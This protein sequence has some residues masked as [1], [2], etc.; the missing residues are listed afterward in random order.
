MVK[1]SLSRPSLGDARRR[2]AA[3]EVS[4][5][6]QRRIGAGLAWTMRVWCGV[7]CASL[8]AVWF[9]IMLVRREFPRA[10]TAEGAGP[11]IAVV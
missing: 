6:F 7:V 2:G 9:R 5:R 11:L 1:A 10:E 8:A 3:R 4:A